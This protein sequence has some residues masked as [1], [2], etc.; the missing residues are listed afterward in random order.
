[1]APGAWSSGQ[2]GEVTDLHH[3]LPR[4]ELAAAGRPQACAAGGTP[5][6]SH[7]L[8]SPGEGGLLVWGSKWGGLG[9]LRAGRGSTQ[10]SLLHGGPETRHPK[11]QQAPAHLWVPSSGSPQAHPPSHTAGLSSEGAHQTCFA[12]S[13]IG[14]K[15][16]HR[17][18]KLH[19]ELTEHRN[20]ALFL[21]HLCFARCQLKTSTA[22][23]K[24]KKKNQNLYR[25]RQ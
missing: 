21:H 17:N 10:E 14:E 5:S 24:K 25:P 12:I 16:A 1:M 6:C 22:K 7:T 13:T 8:H 19:F 18:C 23:K 11:A 3:Q 20:L 15:S 2:L 9:L 4:A